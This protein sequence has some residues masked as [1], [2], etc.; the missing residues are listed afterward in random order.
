MDKDDPNKGIPPVLA[1]LMEFASSAVYGKISQS[2]SCL[3]AWMT[4]AVAP[5]KLERR[6]IKISEGFDTRDFD[7]PLCIQIMVRA[8]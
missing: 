2:N 4:R 5:F 7:C 8:F 3:P 6:P 1:T